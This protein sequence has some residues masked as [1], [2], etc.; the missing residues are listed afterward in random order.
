MARSAEELDEIVAVLQQLT[1]ED[2]DSSD[3]R[4]IYRFVEKDD[5]VYALSILEDQHEIGGILRWSKTEGWR[6][7]ALQLDLF[8]AL[9]AKTPDEKRRHEIGA[10]ADWWRRVKLTLVRLGV[11]SMPEITLD[12][13]DAHDA[14]VS[15]WAHARRLV[16]AT[17]GAETEFRVAMLTDTD[18]GQ[19]VAYGPH[20]YRAGDWDEGQWRRFIRDNRITHFSLSDL[21]AEPCTAETFIAAFPED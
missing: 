5:S 15:S 21:S 13:V 12:D 20:R 14:D 1:L 7:I 16:G 9:T 19:I 6:F 18:N 17:P 2:G 8:E 11:R 10:L 3:V 4:R